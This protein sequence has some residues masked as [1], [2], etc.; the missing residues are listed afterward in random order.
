M[1]GLHIESW[2]L[3][4]ALLATL[5]YQ[6]ANHN[7][8][9][10][11]VAGEGFVVSLVPLLVQRLSK[12]HVPRALEF[13]FVLGMALQFISESSKLFELFTYWDKIVHSTLVALTAVV[14]AWLLLGYRDAFGKR[15]PTQFA[16]LFGL[17]MGMCIG[18]LWEFIEFGSDY[19][20]DANLQKSNG[21]TMTDI[22]GND[23][24]AFSATLLGVW[25]YCHVL[26]DQQR[27]EMGEVAVW[28]AHGPR[29]LFQ[30]HGRLVGAALAVLFAGVLFLSQWVDRNQPALASGL[31]NGHSNHWDFVADPTGGTLVLAGDWVADPRGICRVNLEQPKPGSEKMGLLVLAPGE[32]YGVDG[33]PY[34]VQVRYFEE[35]P[36]ISQGTEMD[37]GIAFGTRDAQDFD[38]LEQSALHDLLRLDH[39]VHGKRRDLR[40]KLYRT[41]GNEW[42]MLSV[43][44]AGAHVTASVD[45]QAIFAVDNVPSTSGEIGLWARTAAATCFSEADVTVGAAG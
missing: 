36:P 34:S 31:A 37:A 35:R 38:L 22:I 25:F 11:T 29:R 24:G 43:D 1:K 15:I 28:L 21:D 18:A 5:A 45:S 3:R 16:A 40:E 6:L 7:T 27:R 19:F 32:A 39:Y 23:L 14:G 13:A 4:L 2:L 20:G 10:A 42:H 9:G 44:V 33:Q 41:H 12:V 8:S 17:L 26:N 30:H